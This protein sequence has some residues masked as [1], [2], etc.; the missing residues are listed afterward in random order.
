MAK[1][2][3]PLFDDLIDDALLQLQHKKIIKLLNY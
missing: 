2:W 3:L 1:H